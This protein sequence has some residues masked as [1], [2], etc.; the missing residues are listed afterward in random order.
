LKIRT[1]DF[2]RILT[3]TKSNENENYVVSNLRLGKGKYS[4]I[5]FTVEKG[6][7]AYFY[8]ELF[9]DFRENLINFNFKP[10][11]KV[12]EPS[13][14]NI[15]ALKP[16]ILKNTL[17][18]SDFEGTIL[19]G[20]KDN[21][22]LLMP[23]TTSKIIYKEGVTPKFGNQKTTG[24]GG[25]SKSLARTNTSATTPA[26]TGNFNK[27]LFDLKLD[28][29][30]EYEL[31]AALLGLESGTN[32]TSVKDKEGENAD[33]QEVDYEILASLEDIVDFNDYGL[34]D[35][36]LDALL[37]VIVQ[38]KSIRKLS[39]AGNKLTDQSIFDLSEK[40]EVSH[41]FELEELD[42]S[43]NNLGKQAADT[44]LEMIRTFK[45]LLK[46][47]ISGNRDIPDALRNKIEFTLKKK[48]ATQ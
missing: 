39:L 8:C 24:R 15:A 4:L 48:E 11:D 2:K 18:L 10:W 36:G 45:N 7:L 26:K 16:R 12:L 47:N 37:D 13:F 33:D 1:P 32:R 14:V 41:H 35:V 25:M 46:I 6:E 20:V 23:H 28:G 31:T 40:L 3:V 30:Y 42:L 19:H 21:I 9:Y 27:R 22:M 43:D 5:P 29:Q 44:I 17:K 34:T 38:N